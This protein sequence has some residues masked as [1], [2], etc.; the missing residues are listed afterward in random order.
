MRGLGPR[1][2]EKKTLPLDVNIGGGFDT[3]ISKERKT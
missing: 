3:N 2:D 1:G